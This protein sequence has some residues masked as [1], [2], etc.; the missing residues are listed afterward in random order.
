MPRRSGLAREGF[1]P[2]LKSFAAKA[3]PTWV[4]LMGLGFRLNRWAK[5]VSIEC[6]GD[7][8]DV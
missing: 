1:V 3:A 4:K 2:P 7:E 8:L 5:S 6:L